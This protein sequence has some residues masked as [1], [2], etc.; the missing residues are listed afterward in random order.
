MSSLIIFWPGSEHMYLYS[1][2]TVTFGS[3]PANLTTS[4]TLTVAAMFTP[5]SQT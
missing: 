5:Q 2:A 1:R 4:G 3:P